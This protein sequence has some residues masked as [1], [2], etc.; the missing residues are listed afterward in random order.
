MTYRFVNGVPYLTCDASIW[1]DFQDGDPGAPGIIG[2]PGHKLGVELCFPQEM[3]PLA[4]VRKQPF[5]VWPYSPEIESVFAALYWVDWAN[6]QGGVALLNRGTVGYR[7]DAEDR[8]VS[9]ILATGR[10]GEMTMRLGLLPHDGGWLERGVHQ[11]GLGFGHPLYCAY[12]PPHSGTLPRQFQLCRIEP[13]TVTVSSAF[14][15]N[16]KSYLRLFDHA[17]RAAEVR[18][19]NTE[20][21]LSARMVDLRL[22]PIDNEP[23]ICAHGII[24][25]ELDWKG[26]EQR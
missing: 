4:C 13:D 12:E 18:A 20:G 14:R 8:R 7:W 5:L 21:C 3:G 16:G 24:T 11:A 10:L 22:R 23:Q 15:T 17:G 25:L 2:G 6:S 19:D 1:A 26:S 9:N